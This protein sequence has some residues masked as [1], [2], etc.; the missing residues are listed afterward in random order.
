MGIAINHIFLRLGAADAADF[1]ADFLRAFDLDGDFDFELFDFEL[2]DFLLLWDLL[3]ITLPLPL[4]LFCLKGLFLLLR[5]LVL[6]EA[7]TCA[8]I[9]SIELVYDPRG[10]SASSTLGTEGPD[11]LAA[12]LRASISAGGSGERGISGVMGV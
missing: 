2:N 10:N 5:F 12:I 9:A 3:L 7:S 8:A 4:L 6:R 11:G 1:A